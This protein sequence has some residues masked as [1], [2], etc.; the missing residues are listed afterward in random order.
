MTLLE[1]LVRAR[2]RAKLRQEDVAAV[3][4]VDRTEITHIEGGRRGTSMANAEAWANACGY[5]IVLV[6]R[7]PAAADP[8]GLQA[9]VASVEDPAARQVIAELARLVRA[10]HRY[11]MKFL[12]DFRHEAR[13]A[14]RD[15]ADEA[16]NR[17]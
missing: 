5:E 4:G 17:A 10:P 9:L 1:Q 16:A 7:D 11:W 13:R 14:A 8:E 6:P 3:V 12:E 2:K 15:E